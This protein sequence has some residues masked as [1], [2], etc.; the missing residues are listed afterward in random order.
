MARTV[1]RQRGRLGLSTEQCRQR[2]TEIA[3]AVRSGA[4]ADETAARFRVSLSTVCRAC[5]EHGVSFAGGEAGRSL[6]L[7]TRRRA[8]AD[9]VL[10]GMTGPAAAARFGVSEDLV[11]RSCR[12]HGVAAP[13]RLDRKRAASLKARRAAAEA[14]GGAARPKRPSRASTWNRPKGTITPRTAAI[15]RR[16]LTTDDTFAEIARHFG[17]PHQ[18]VQEV[19]KR[20]LLETGR[21]RGAGR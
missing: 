4:M 2:R 21:R 6:L 16:L 3:G 15:R 7:A 20:M 17:V 14:N 18:W 5:R 12:E 11:R 19:L 1:N 9:S 8:I 13:D 10:A